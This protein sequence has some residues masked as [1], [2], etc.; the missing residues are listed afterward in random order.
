MDARWLLAERRAGF[1]VA[2]W[3]APMIAEFLLWKE[4]RYW[5]KRH[6]EALRLM[7][8]ED[9]R[10]LVD[11]P[12]GKAIVERHQR[13]ARSSWYQLDHEPVP[14]FRERMRKLAAETLKVER[15]APSVPSSDAEVMAALGQYSSGVRESLAG[16]YRCRRGLGDEVLDAWEYVLRCHIGENL[17][18]APSANPAESPR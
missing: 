18:K 6:L 9:Y 12:V 15:P 1:P 16:I 13:M 2:W 8:D 3:G 5:E 4:R 11:D 17:G 10:W 14:Q 7:I